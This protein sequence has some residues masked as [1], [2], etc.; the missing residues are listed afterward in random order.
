MHLKNGIYHLQIL[1]YLFTSLI[2]STAGH[3]SLNL[4]SGKAGEFTISLDSNPWLS[5][6]TF[7]Q[8]GQYS[9]KDGTLIQV[10]EY[11]TTG[12]DNIGD[13]VA[14]VFNYT[15]KSDPEKKVI[16]QTIF[17]TYSDN[18]NVMS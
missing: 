16:F 15:K 7:V 2:R 18:D 1:L 14:N 9:T 17:R 6:G 13:Y 3:L 8:V 12:T 5:G 4:Q 10:G 11:N